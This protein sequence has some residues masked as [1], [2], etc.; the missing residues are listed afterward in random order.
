V[1]TGGDDDDLDGYELKRSVVRSMS[2]TRTLITDGDLNMMPSD[3]C[4]GEGSMF[5]YLQNGVSTAKVVMLDK[6][7]LAGG[8]H[9]WWQTRVG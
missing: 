8:G 6:A 3:Y 5:T 2:V 9:W 7:R 1:E 4:E